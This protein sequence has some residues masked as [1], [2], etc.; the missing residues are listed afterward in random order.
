MKEETPTKISIATPCYGGSC[1]VE[2]VAGVLT[3]YLAGLVTNWLTISTE[4]LVPR[5]R[6]R[7][8]H[9]FLEGKDSKLVFVDSDVGFTAAQLK[10]LIDHEEDIVGGC[11]P[12]KTEGKNAGWCFNRLKSG[13]QERGEM[14]EVMETGTGFLSISR[15]VIE[16]LSADAAKI[17]HKETT[18]AELFPV[19]CLD[20]SGRYFS[21]DW[22]FAWLARKAGYQIWVDRGIRL[23]HIG[24]KVYT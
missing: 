11:Y 18:M 3:S 12:K 5:A 2:Y 9:Q 19:G 4:S 1:D 13:E 15:R 14:L 22:G 17:V 23:R 16:E 7:L 24:R 20:G 10:Q 21:E 6:N 8:A